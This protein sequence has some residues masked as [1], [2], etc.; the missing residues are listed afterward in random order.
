MF[1]GEA[2]VRSLTKHLPFDEARLQC[3]AKQKVMLLCLRRLEML[4]HSGGGLAEGLAET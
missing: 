2:A 4:Q 3:V 1:A